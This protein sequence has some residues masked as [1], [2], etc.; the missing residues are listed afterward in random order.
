MAFNSGVLEQLH[1]RA[2]AYSNQRKNVLHSFDI[3]SKNFFEG[4]PETLALLN[5]LKWKE[6]DFDYELL[7]PDKD[8]LD[9]LSASHNRK[10]VKNFVPTLQTF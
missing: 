6:I 10:Q 9:S 7:N 2:I 3:F 5:Y 8:S 1:R 4:R